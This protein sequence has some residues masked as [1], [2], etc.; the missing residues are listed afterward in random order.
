MHDDSDLKLIELM[1]IEKNLDSETMGKNLEK[2]NIWYAIILHF[3]FLYFFVFFKLFLIFIIFFNFFFF[4]L[5][6][7]FILF[8]FV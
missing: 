3:L 4:F 7:I 6:K 2:I 1:K 8:I 5:K